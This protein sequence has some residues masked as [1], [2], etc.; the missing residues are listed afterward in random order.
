MTTIV[1]SVPADRVFL[2]AEW[3]YLAMLNYEVDAKLLGKFVPCGTELDRFEGRVF[4][5]LVGFRF[6]NTRV[7]GI[8]IPF[9]CNFDEVNLRFYVRRQVGNEVRRGVVFIREIVPRWAIAMVARAFYN[10]QYV[11][12]PMRHEIRPNDGTL[13]ANYQWRSAGAWASMRVE[14]AGE[15]QRSREGSEEQFIT[16][17]YW[18]YAAQ[19]NGPT[20][21]YQVTHPSWRVWAANR[22]NFSGEVEGLYGREFAAVLRQTPRSAFLAEGSPIAVLRGRRM[23][24]PG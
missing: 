15:P 3:R 11:A 10:E 5:S 18:G 24:Y 6:L 14:V 19:R 23:V 20:V 2:T 12:L 13:A 22:A 7:L 17:H 8:P 9:H 16:E 4:L 1:N 21:E